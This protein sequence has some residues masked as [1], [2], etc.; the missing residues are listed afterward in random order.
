MLN[1]SGL[2]DYKLKIEESR[3]KEEVSKIVMGGRLC[4]DIHVLGV[5][6]QFLMKSKGLNKLTF[7]QVGDISFICN[8]HCIPIGIL[9]GVENSY[10]PEE[11]SHYMRVER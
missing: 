6:M 5:E 1:K 2:S 3:A 4:K 8:Q 7:L 11:S 10:Q 9:S